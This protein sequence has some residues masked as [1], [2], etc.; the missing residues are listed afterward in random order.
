MEIKEANDEK[1]LHDDVSL[2]KKPKPLTVDQ[3]LKKLAE[4]GRK[5]VVEMAKV[6]ERVAALRQA[7]T[8]AEAVFNKALMD[9]SQKEKKHPEPPVN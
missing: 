6:Q 9:E 5:E 1:K 8:D 3:A 4:V 7:R 2:P